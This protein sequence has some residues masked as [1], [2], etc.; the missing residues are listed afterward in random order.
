MALEDLTGPAKFID[1][2]VTG[3]PLSNDDRREGDDHIRGIKNIL[4]NTFPAF[5]GAINYTHTQ[6][7]DVI[8][9]G[10]ASGPALSK[11]ANLADVPD[12]AAGRANL[13]VPGYADGDARWLVKGSNLED[14]PDKPLSLQNIGLTNADA[15][16]LSKSA[17]EGFR[18]DTAPVYGVSIFNGAFSWRTWYVGGVY[19][20]LFGGAGVVGALNVETADVV[21]FS[22]TSFKRETAIANSD[23]SKEVATTAYVQRKTLAEQA[24]YTNTGRVAN[25]DYTVTSSSPEWS[26]IWLTM[27]P[28]GGAVLWVDGVR[29]AVETNGAAVAEERTVYAMAKPGSVIKLETTASINSWLTL[30]A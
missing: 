30:K 25:V 18:S 3:N 28:G 14:V 2:L 8:A 4:R 19:R 6:L 24:T 29:W 10:V 11:A 21:T 17:V 7:N 16:V 26:V 27:Y 20:L 15:T 5:S 12:K 1:A 22:L 9:N 13:G 23:N